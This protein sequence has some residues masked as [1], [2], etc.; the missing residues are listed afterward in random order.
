MEIYDP[1]FQERRQFGGLRILEPA[2]CQIYVPQSQKLLVYRGLIKNIS[3]GGL[4]FSCDD[5]PPLKKDDIRHLIFDIIYN[6]YKLYRLK[7]HGL[8]VRTENNGAEFG[9]ALKLLSDPLYYP[10]K[11]IDDG[12]LPSLDKTRLLCQNYELY[13]KAY[14]VIKTTPDIRSDKV[15]HI[16]N[17]LSHNLYQIDTIK[18]AK[19]LW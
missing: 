14:A 11:E 19:I 8:V 17:R 4:Y 9:V 13:R 5:E 7:F 2:L 6:Y 16:K 15:D 10:L 3:L 18:L 12:E 1:H